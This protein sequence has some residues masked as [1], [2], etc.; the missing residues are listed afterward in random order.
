L[1]PV[2]VLAPQAAGSATGFLL[3]EGGDGMCAEAKLSLLKNSNYRKD[4]KD[5]Q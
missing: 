4:G 3:S 5:V 1:L 2:A